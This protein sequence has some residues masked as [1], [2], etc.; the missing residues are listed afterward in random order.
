MT[1][2][3]TEARGMMDSCDKARYDD[4]WRSGYAEGIWRFESGLF[5]PPASGD[6]H[7]GDVEGISTE[8]DPWLAGR[9]DGFIA[10]LNGPPVW[11]TLEDGRVVR[12]SEPAPR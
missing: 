8:T 7:T 2:T 11:R 5:P 6:V 3:P 1:E 9:Q 12:S 4:G 10:G